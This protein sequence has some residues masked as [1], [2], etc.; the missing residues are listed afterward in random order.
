MTL[1]RNVLFKKVIKG[2][3]KGRM[4]KAIVSLYKS[5]QLCTFKWAMYSLARC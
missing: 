2:C 1:N 3:I 4:F 5:V